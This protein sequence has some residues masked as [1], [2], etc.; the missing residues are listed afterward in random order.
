MSTTPPAAVTVVID[1]LRVV[2]ETN[3]RGHWSRQYRR[4]RGQQDIVIPTL[5]VRLDVRAWSA[6]P[7]LRVTLQ[8]V[9]APRG[10]PFDRDNLWSS[11]KHVIDGT[12]TVFGRPDDDPWF[13]WQV[14]SEQVRGK[15]YGVRIR[16]E[17]VPAADAAGPTREG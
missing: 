2:G 12:A 16:F 17:A 9:Y 13:D 11:M 5:R 14:N 6:V 3:Q 4:N 10:R 15:E 8:R 7:R 1:G